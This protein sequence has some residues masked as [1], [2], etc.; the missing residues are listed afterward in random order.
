MKI[1]EQQFLMDIEIEEDKQSE[2]IIISQGGAVIVVA[3]ESISE[4]IITLQTPKD[5]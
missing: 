1:I 2:S 5:K 4:L 3:K